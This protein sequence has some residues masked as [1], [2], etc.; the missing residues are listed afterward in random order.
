M[1]QASLAMADLPPTEAA[2]SLLMRDVQMSSS[3]IDES[4]AEAARGSLQ[5]SLR[6]G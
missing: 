3:S 1:A 4:N 6:E 2:A 5:G